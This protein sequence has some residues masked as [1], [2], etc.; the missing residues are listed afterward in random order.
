MG[1]RVVKKKKIK[2]KSFEKRKEEGKEG[3]KERADEKKR[4]SGSGRLSHGEWNQNFIRKR[5]SHA[6]THIK[7]DDVTTKHVSGQV[8]RGYVNS[9][10][11]KQEWKNKWGL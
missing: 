4:L 6:T 9:L 3:K 5:P 8:C 11:P 1:Q 7:N 2:E 10:P